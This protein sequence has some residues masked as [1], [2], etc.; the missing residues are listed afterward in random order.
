MNQ[1]IGIDL[2]GTN[3]KAALVDTQS[4]KI[5]ATLSKPTRDGEF[6]GNT[7]RFAITVR[8][9]VA[10]LET[11]AGQ[12]LAVGLSA[13]FLSAVSLFMRSLSLR[14][15]PAVRDYYP[16][17]LGMCRVGHVPFSLQCAVNV[18]CTPYITV[19]FLLTACAVNL[20]CV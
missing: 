1:A 15:V 4:A 9:I 16:W 6:D 13:E 11:Q 17:T 18:R 3:I 8:E 10:E 12:K 2:G 19:H 14:E 5:I 7:P 20:T